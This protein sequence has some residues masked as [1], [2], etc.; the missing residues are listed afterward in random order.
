[1]SGTDERTAVQP[2]RMRL[3]G[4][5]WG[6]FPAQVIRTLVALDV[7]DRLAAAPCGAGELAAA[8]DADPDAL[9]R[10]LRAAAGLGLLDRD[11][12]GSWSLTATGELLRTGVPG[13]MGQLSRLFCDDACWRSWGQLEW[14]VRTGEVAFEKV[15]GHSAFEYMAGEAQLAGIFTA[16]MAEGTRAAG[17]GVVEVCDLAGVDTLVDVGGGNGTLLRYFLDRH[18]G[19]RGI[20]FD[21]PVGIGTEQVVDPARA[22]VV[23]GDMFVAVPR[24]DAYVVKSVVHDWDDERAVA[25][26]TRIREAM[27]AHGRVFVVEPVLSDDVAGLAGQ[28]TTLMSDLNMLVC[29]GG[30][31][32]TLAEF[33]AVLDAAGLRLTD[34]IRVPPP[35]GFSVL[36]AV[37]A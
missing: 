13:A 6:F 35:T 16:A 37:K 30:R 4:Y 32:R 5:L 19:L 26:L 28:Y 22:E 20:L 8:V 9:A 11:A 18:P 31:E 34:T 15:T 3:A 17:P 36:R 2:D 27:P 12:A 10:L 21:T 24:A 29:A 23:T 7:P 33:G 25:L 14:S 1:M